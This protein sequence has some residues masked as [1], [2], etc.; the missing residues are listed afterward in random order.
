V[1][2]GLAAKS[3][4]TSRRAAHGGAAFRTLKTVFVSALTA[5]A[6]LAFVAPYYAVSMDGDERQEAATQ[7]TALESI[8]IAVPHRRSG[9]YR[10]T[11][12]FF[13]TFDRPASTSV[14]ARV[15]TYDLR[16][17]LRL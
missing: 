11:V 2:T 7:S 3:V 14:R 5:L 16:T 8:R 15:L 13:S 10:N 1:R 6:L 9:H 4:A 17:R 12:A